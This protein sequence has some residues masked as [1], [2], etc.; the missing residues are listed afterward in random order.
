MI[1]TQVAAFLAA[2]LGSNLAFGAEA[3]ELSWS[4]IGFH[5]VNL[6]ILLAGFVY[7][8]R[9]PLQRALENRA[10]A[11][12]REI[13]EAARLQAEAKALLDTYEGKLAQLEAEG[14][15]LLRLYREEGE[16]EKARMLAEA[17]TEADRIRREA[18][19]A[20]ETEVARARARLEA[21]VVDLAIDAATRTI[22]EK[23][24]AADHRRLTA[25]YLSRL[26]ES[27]GG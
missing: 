14:A 16:A 26:E 13:A 21:E 24:T 8:A 1:R 9:R 7:F 11:V 10:D 5:A 22:A 17:Q 20:A 19:R 15:E 6:A 3:G 25:D 2:S 4:T 18:Q 23:M 12:G 27:A